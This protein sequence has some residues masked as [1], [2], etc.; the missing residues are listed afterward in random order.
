MLD[1]PI[2]IGILI[3]AGLAV[4]YCFAGGIRASI[5]TDGIQSI[6]MM[7]GGFIL[8]VVAVKEVGG[9]GVLPLICEQSTRGWQ[10]YF[11]RITNSISFQQF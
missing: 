5:W 6:V 4:A 10:I 7:V 1:W 9:L 2:W 11:R 3:G 8:C